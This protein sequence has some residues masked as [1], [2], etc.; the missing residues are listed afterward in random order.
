MSKNENEFLN[1]PFK[2]YVRIRPMLD[3]EVN[4][5][6]ESEQSSRDLEIEKSSSYKTGI[7]VVDNMVKTIFLN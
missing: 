3:K 7:K 5:D 4:Y 6:K 1:D 2:V